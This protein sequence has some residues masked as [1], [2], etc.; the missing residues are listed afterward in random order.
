MPRKTFKKII[1]SDELINQINPENKKLV[2]R[3]LKNYKTKRSPKSVATYESNYNIFFC[4]N[5]IYNENKVFTDIKK[6]EMQDFFDYGVDTLKWG[7]ARFAQV[8]SSL[9]ELSRYIENM[10]DEFYPNFRNIMPKIEKLIKEPK[11]E[12]SVFTKQELDSLMN[13]LEENKEY[14]QCALLSLMIASGARI[15]E[16]NRFH[17]DIID[18]NNTAYDGIFIETLKE[19][20]VKGRGTSGKKML[21]Y[22]I[23]DL[24]VDNYIRWLPLRE[25]IMK[26]NNQE[27]NY[28]FIKSDG[29][30]AKNSTFRS[31]MSKWD[32]FLEKPF[33]AHSLRHHWCSYCLSKG[34]DKSLVQELQQWSTDSLVDLYDDRT[35]KDKEWKGLDKFK[36]NLESDLKK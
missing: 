30:P 26:K 11:R 3:F 2:E 10:L 16:L 14:Q 4:W 27:H 35:A 31:W 15:S 29:T 9:G 17:I 13:H 34:L 23:K 32:E 36:E 33:Y 8:H 22:I 12:K 21:R 20:V 25:E 5:L 18:I 24:F 19:Q 6:L 1:T 7:S 28:L